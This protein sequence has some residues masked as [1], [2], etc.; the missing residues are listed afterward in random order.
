MP[1]ALITGITGFVGPYLAHGLR[2]RGIECVGIGRAP[3]SRLHP[4][5]LSPFRLRDL[6]IRDRPAVRWLIREEQ[7]DLV[8]HLAAVTHVPASLADPELAFDVNVGGTLNLFESLRQSAPAARVLFVSTGNL[9]GAIES[10]TQGFSEDSPLHLASPYAASKQ[11]GEQLAHT[12]VD[13]FAMNIVVARPFNHTGPGQDTSFACP[14]FA[15]AIAEGVVRNQS[16]HMKTGLLQ[17]RR[18]ITDVRDV[19]NA[20]L[21]LAERGLTGETYN[22]CS[23]SSVSMEEVIATLSRLAGVS[24]TTELDPARV[25]QREIMHS[26]GNSSR[27]RA[28]GWTPR[29]SLASTLQDLL[30]FWI[31]HLH[32]ANHA[33]A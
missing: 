3:A 17:P 33:P 25:R 7:P 12:W 23:G 6:D 29:I 18:D 1:R 13:D 14:A 8:F 16:V 5:S 15:R 31:E 21:L 27:L 10:G 32:N 24:V 22:V 28:L 20:Y 4:L 19:V 30:N 9:Y 11:M 2:T 26:G